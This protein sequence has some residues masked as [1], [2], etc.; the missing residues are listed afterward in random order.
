MA[1]YDPVRYVDECRKPTVQKTETVGED[2]QKRRAQ[3]IKEKLPHRINAI[4]PKATGA[5][6]KDQKMTFKSIGLK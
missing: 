1:T 3:P 2:Q 6:K 5:A 4:A